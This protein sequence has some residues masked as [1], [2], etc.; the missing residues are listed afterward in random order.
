[1]PVSNTYVT[2]A[3]IRR[4]VYIER[5]KTGKSTAYD[6][7]ALAIRRALIKHLSKYNVTKISE[8]NKFELRALIKDIDDDVQG[9]EKEFLT[10]LFLWL[11][12]YSFREAKHSTEVFNRTL[13]VKNE[14]EP[15]E[16]SIWGIVTGTYIAAL[17]LTP[18]ETM[19]Q[20]SAHQRTQIKKTIR[21]AFSQAWTVSQLKA[22]ILGLAA[23]RFKTGVIARA[24]RTIQTGINTIIQ[25]A[26]SLARYKVAQKF[27]EF[28][29]NY[30]WVSILDGKTSQQCRA[31]D[32]QIFSYGEGPLPPIH[33]NCRSHTIPIFKDGI[34]F[35]R[36]VT[37][38]T[39]SGVIGAGM[40]YYDWLLTQSKAFQIDVLGPTRAKIFRSGKLTPKQFADLDLNKNFKPITLDE[41]EKKRPELFDD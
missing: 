27:I 22:E 7:V 41:L 2:D 1:M 35:L 29:A 15:S 23:T 10:E 32:G 25:H 39:S 3:L 14:K 36:G 40:N 5:L 12:D 9:A 8:L 4:Q 11:R 24:R 28:G 16:S 34:S 38:K 18:R 37:R 31:L 21:Q 33:P 13:P 6:G 26:A 17:G 20:W 30:E 19:R